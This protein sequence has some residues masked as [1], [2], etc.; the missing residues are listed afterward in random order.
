MDSKNLQ[1][2]RLI[3]LGSS[4]QARFLIMSTLRIYRSCEKWGHLHFQNF[5]F[6]STC[7]SATVWTPV[8]AENL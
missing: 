4:Q 8:D 7:N 5:V 6:A 1:S 3:T 2:F